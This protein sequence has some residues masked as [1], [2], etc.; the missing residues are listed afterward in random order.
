[1]EKDQHLCVDECAVE[2]E[3]GVNN[4]EKCS[5]LHSSLSNMECAVVNKIKPHMTDFQSFTH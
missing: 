1:M 3:G 5:T 4:K 2:E